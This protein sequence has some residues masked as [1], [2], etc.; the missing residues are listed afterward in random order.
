[1]PL[2]K[3]IYKYL[4]SRTCMDR[5]PNQYK[6]PLLCACLNSYY[7]YVNANTIWTQSAEWTERSR[8]TVG[9]IA[10][11]VQTLGANGWKTISRL[12][13]YTPYPSVLTVAAAVAALLKESFIWLHH[14]LTVRLCHLTGSNPDSLTHW[15]SAWR[16]SCSAVQH[17]ATWRTKI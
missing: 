3:K 16:I 2:L 12:Y 7:F 5:Q 11:S 4:T 15:G 1:M 6:Q 8:A 10:S 14:R 9:M 13:I 17:N